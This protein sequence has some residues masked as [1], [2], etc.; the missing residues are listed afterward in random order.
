MCR[1]YFYLSAGLDDIF[2]M[3]VFAVKGR[4]AAGGAV[5]AP[6][7]ANTAITQ[8]LL[9]GRQLPCMPLLGISSDKTEIS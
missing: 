7:T 6:F 4:A 3:A 9:P 1:T 5:R 8:S 2:P